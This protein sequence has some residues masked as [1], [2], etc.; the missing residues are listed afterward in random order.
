M[1]VKVKMIKAGLGF[2]MWALGAQVV[3]KLLGLF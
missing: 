2:I 1:K 3:L